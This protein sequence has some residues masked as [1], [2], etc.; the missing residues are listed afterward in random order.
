MSSRPT[1]DAQEFFRAAVDEVGGKPPLVLRNLAQ[2]L[3]SLA[4]AIERLE[5]GIKAK[6]S[7]RK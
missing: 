7:K 3:L 4:E 2:G 6:K 1:K 5:G